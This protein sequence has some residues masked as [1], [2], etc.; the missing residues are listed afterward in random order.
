L[1]ELSSK[2]LSSTGA[3]HHDFSGRDADLED[4]QKLEGRD[5]E[6][7]MECSALGNEVDSSGGA[8]E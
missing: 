1:D 7:N 8:W 2:V 5:L 4:I 6:G 3:K